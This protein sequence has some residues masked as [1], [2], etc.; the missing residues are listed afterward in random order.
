MA[1]VYWTVWPSG[2]AEQDST[3]LGKMRGKKTV[4]SNFKSPDCCSS[5]RALRKKTTLLG[6]CSA[7]LMIGIIYGVFAHRVYFGH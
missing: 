6:L 4:V 2:I 1:L 7:V 3:E 5:Q